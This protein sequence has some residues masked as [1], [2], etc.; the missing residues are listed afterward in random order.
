MWSPVHPALFACVDGMGRLDLWNLNN[1]TEVSGGAGGGGR[2]GRGRP[3]SVSSSLCSSG[4]WGSDPP[5][6]AGLPPPALE[7][8]GRC[9]GQKSLHLTS[10]RGPG[11][12][13]AAGDPFLQKAKRCPPKGRTRRRVP[14]AEITV[15]QRSEREA[16]VG[17]GFRSG[18]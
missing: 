14:G 11:R 12:R 16:L 18:F 2:A 9:T 1:D 13:R 6:A 17:A 5:A 15:G 3:P 8:A 10:S 7:G 4:L